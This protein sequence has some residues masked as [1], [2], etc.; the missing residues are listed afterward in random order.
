[1]SFFFSPVDFLLDTS[2]R[3]KEYIEDCFYPIE[4]QVEMEEEVI[5]FEATS[6]EQKPTQTVFSK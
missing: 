6:I 5:S 1:M 4:I 3:L 2:V